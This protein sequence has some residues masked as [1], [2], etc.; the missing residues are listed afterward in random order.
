MILKWSGTLLKHGIK[1][2]HGGK[3][4]E[5]YCLKKKFRDKNQVT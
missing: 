3:F 2:A 4:A 5:L 1:A